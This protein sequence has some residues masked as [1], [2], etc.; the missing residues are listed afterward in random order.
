MWAAAAV[1]EHRAVR[2]GW[3]SLLRLGAPFEHGQRRARG[4]REGDALQ[5]QLA[6]H[7]GRPLA[8]RVLDAGRRRAALDD[9]QQARHGHGAAA[10]VHRLRQR[11]GNKGNPANV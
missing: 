2:T 1:Q 6:L 11:C 10:E 5:A 4:V 7:A 8:G 9:R 3:H